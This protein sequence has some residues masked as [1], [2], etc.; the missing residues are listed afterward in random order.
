MT[1]VAAL[2]DRRPFFKTMRKDNWWASPAATFLVFSTFVVYTTWALFQGEHYWYGPYLSPFYSPELF[3]HS[4]HAVFGTDPPWWPPFIKYSPA[5]L[6]LLAPLGFRMTCYYYRGAYYKAFWADPPACAVGEPRNGYRG[7]KKL[8]LTVM[9]IHRYFLYLAVLF[10]VM[11]SW[12]AIKAFKWDDG[13]HVNV[14]ALLMTLNVSLIGLY[15]FGCHSLRHLI[16]GGRDQ[17]PRGAVGKNCYDC[18]SA[19]NKKHQL[20]AWSSLFSVGLT[21]VYIRLCSMGVITDLRL[22]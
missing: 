12:D 4:P 11:L 2:P 10:I 5:M 16:G 22:F 17:L 18:V 14:G 1:P 9:N 13:F 8:P 19:L 20:F 3:G 7:E 6:I 15:T 21:D